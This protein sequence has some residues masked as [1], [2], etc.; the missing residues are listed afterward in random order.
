MP[1]KSLAA[2]FLAA[3]ALP[4]FAQN[5]A[6]QPVPYADPI[7]AAKD[8]PYP[9]TM[10]VAIDATDT[11]RGIFRIKQTVPVA[12]PGPLTMLYP[13]W[14]PGAHSP[15]GQIASVAGVVITAN[16]KP[17]EW[18]RDPVDV[19]AFTVV[20][21]AGVKSID[22][23]FQYLSATAGPQGRIV[24]TPDMLNLQWI[25]QTLYPAGYFTRQIP[26]SASV[27]YPEGFK[28]ATALEVA[29]TSGNT[30]NYKTVSYETLADSPIYAGRYYRQE[31]LG[32]GVRLNVIGDAPKDIVI[33]PEV[34]QLHKN[35]YTQ[36]VKTFGA[37]H[38]DHYDFLFSISEKMGG[39]GLEHQRSSENGVGIGY[40][41]DWDA[42]LT[43]HDL[44]PHEYTHSWN[45]K[46]R[47]GADAWTPDFRTPMRDSMLWVYEGQTQFWGH[48]LSAR[49]GMVSKEDALGLLANDAAVYDYRA[50]RNWRP[51]IDTTN[52]PIIAQRRPKPWLSWQRSEDYYVEGS[53]TWLDANA[54]I[55]EKSGGTKS[56][57]DFARAFFGVRDRDWG[58]LTYD[59]DTVVETLNSVVPY[60]WATFLKEH[61]YS[62][63]PRAPLDWIAKGGYRLDYTPEPTNFTKRAEKSRKAIDLSYSLGL[64]IGK[65]G[66]VSGVM[67]DGPAFDQGITIG[68][69]I[70][71]VAGR[72]YSDDGIKAAITEAAKTKA[73]VKL[74]IKQG[75]LYRPIEIAYFGGL[76]YPRL[77][78]IGTG[79][80]S[81]DALLAPRK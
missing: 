66:A 12:G 56:M 51:V 55:A 47:R 11:Q 71:A 3:T 50:G 31:L 32:P 29:S 9:G 80:G 13:K 76:R 53:L 40:F 15:S 4:A 14:I 23:A 42:S 73:P 77:V 75:D 39:N 61:I 72:A 54:I 24:A 6:P 44:L 30:V 57:D 58:Q 34:L 8:V 21:P 67:W 78:K 37:Q 59:F 28:A 27:T 74:L 35:L 63:R 62:I 33:K 65:E 7:P 16:G 26:V 19:Y 10:T 60:D 1:L 46:Y 41:T 43:D 2:L 48:I 70:V 36:A 49:S 17:L 38:Y 20:V 68:T 81:L 22:V 79:E 25:S 18:T 69:T 5:S 45:G 64:S 52:D